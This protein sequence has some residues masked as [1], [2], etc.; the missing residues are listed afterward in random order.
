MKKRI[1]F[2]YPSPNGKVLSRGMPVTGG[3]RGQVRKFAIA[4]H[5]EATLQQ[6]ND[7]GIQLTGERLAV[8]CPL[9][10]KSSAFNDP[11]VMSPGVVG[12]DPGDAKNPFLGDGGSDESSDGRSEITT[13]E[14]VEEARGSHPLESK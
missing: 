1:C 9:C 6:A 14:P 7:A 3:K 2:L 4:C 11:S 13:P 12:S 8:S 5:P 10:K